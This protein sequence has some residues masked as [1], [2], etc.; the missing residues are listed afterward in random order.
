MQS[1]WCSGAVCAL[2]HGVW[3]ADAMLCGCVCMSQAELA[4][5]SALDAAVAERD[6]NGLERAVAVAKEAALTPSSNPH[7]KAATETLVGGCAG[8][9]AA[10]AWRRRAR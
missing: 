6:I 1:A 9:V 8:G 10:W 3:R 5:E 2:K 4:A 7:M